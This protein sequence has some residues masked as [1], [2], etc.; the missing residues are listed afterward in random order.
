[1]KALVA[2]AG[3]FIGSAARYLLGGAV[4]R[5]VPK[6]AYPLATTMINI[7]GC[8]AIGLIAGAAEAR[9]S[10]SDP[11]RIFLMVGILGGFTTFSTF[12]YETL[13]LMRDARLGLAAANVVIQLTVGLAAVW[14]GM[15]LTRAF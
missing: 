3:G 13:V 5:T 1:M 15:R 10:I 7:L 9:G 4:T 14:F 11:L 6:M 12:G 8:L 2:G